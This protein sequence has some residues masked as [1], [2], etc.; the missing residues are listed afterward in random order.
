MSGLRDE[1]IESEKIRSDLLKWKLIGVAGLGAAGL[2]LNEASQHIDSYLILPLIPPVCFYIDLLCRHTSLRILVIA[3][4]A[5]STADAEDHSYECFVKNL[6][7]KAGAGSGDSKGMIF[8]LE[9][10]ALEWST[11]ALSV[12]IAGLGF[13]AQHP[14]G[15]H[16]QFAD[17]IDDKATFSFLS[18]GFGAVGVIS[19]LA[20]KWFFT[21]Q[22]K[23][24]D[25]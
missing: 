15:M 14:F 8:A 21:K 16:I 13:L 6:R 25:G 7:S 24:L 9:D 2:G 19:T 18:I 17:H 20:V 23:L 10:W 3:S 1:I 12:M 22:A 11:I 4:F 5:R